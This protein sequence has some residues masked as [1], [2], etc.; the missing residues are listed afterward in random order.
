MII[1]CRECD[2]PM[3]ESKKKRPE[4]LPPQNKWMLCQQC[5]KGVEVVGEIEEVG[6]VKALNYTESVTIT[7]YVTIKKS[8]KGVIKYCYSDPER[9]KL[10]SE[11]SLG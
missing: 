5:E 2:E 9:K 7:Q 6:E 1:K 8:S 11:E 3:L 10:L 4:N